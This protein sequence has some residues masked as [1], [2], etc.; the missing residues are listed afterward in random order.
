MPE[1]DEEVWVQIRAEYEAGQS[2]VSDIADAH[3]TTNRS[4]Y[5]HAERDGWTMRV[6]KLTGAMV[7]VPA[8][9]R[10]LL[11]GKLSAL[12]EQQLM[13]IEQQG[14]GPERLANLE[15]DCHALETLSR[16]FDRIVQAEIRGQTLAIKPKTSPQETS[17]PKSQTQQKPED[18]ADETANSA[19]KTQRLRTELAR[20]FFGLQHAR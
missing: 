3:G 18:L 5:L 9:R 15:R 10:K 19:T 14:N 17:A 6:P 13:I 8:G 11:I 20:R 2:T 4:L 7:G 16:A 1:L 12:F